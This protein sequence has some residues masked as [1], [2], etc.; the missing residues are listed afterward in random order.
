MKMTKSDKTP[1]PEDEDGIHQ[2]E[3]SEETPDEK[4]AKKKI[5]STSEYKMKRAEVSMFT[6][7]KITDPSFYG[8]PLVP[9]EL[10]DA[11]KQIEIPLDFFSEGLALWIKQIAKARGT[12]EA[13]IAAALLAAMGVLIGNA[14]VGLTSS[15]WPVPPHLY[16][17]LV[18]DPASGKSPALSAVTGLVEKLEA[19]LRASQ[20]RRG[21]S[22]VPDADRQKMLRLAETLGTP[23]Q[24]PHDNESAGPKAQLICGN[25]SIAGFE[26]LAMDHPRGMLMKFDEIAELFGAKGTETRKLLLSVYDSDA[27]RRT[28]DGKNIYIRRPLFGVVGNIQPDVLERIIV[29]D[30][31]DGFLPRFLAVT[32]GASPAAELSVAVDDDTVM[33]TLRGLYSLDL[34]MS[35]DAPVPQALRFTDEATELLAR[36]SHSG[37]ERQENE[38]E[39]IS[40]ILGKSGA[41]VGRLSLVKTLAD[42]AARG[43]DEPTSIEA[44]AV[45]ESTRFFEDFLLP[46]SRAAY[47]P[48]LCAPIVRQAR[49]QVA[50]LRVMNKSRV[51]KHEI[52]KQVGQKLGSS[53]KLN[54]VLA[55][56]EYEG[57]LRYVPPKPPG[58]KGGRPSP[59]YE[60]NPRIFRRNGR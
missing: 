7:S 54:P 56:L 40:K 26:G 50:L 13:F 51:S 55:Y 14:R 49:A 15:G 18:G 43:E 60:V 52:L 47:E 20:G 44:D 39:L 34:E 59:S 28:V 38:P 30:L 6:K 53:D 8:W 23:L 1:R 37:R 36:A 45:R 41:T 19:E 16:F 58:P 33:Q 24:D 29:K 11:P 42:A 3:H 21:Q 46:M 27:H 2:N 57:V 35:D 9:P 5:D 10:L 4:I 12:S 22:G 25:M 32:S 48:A 17:L 31:I